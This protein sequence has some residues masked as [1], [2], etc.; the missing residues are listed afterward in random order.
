MPNAIKYN[1]S[2]ETLALKKGNFYIGTGDVGKGPTSSTG[3]Y[4]G[5]TPP[6]G[7]YTIYLNKAVVDQVNIYG[8]K[9]C[10]INRINIINCWSKFN[11]IRSMF[12]LVC[13][14]N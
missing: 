14:T 7:G 1:V 10:S 8:I 12:K 3:Y 5:I 2:D 11:N 6:S 13:N 4:N 9:C